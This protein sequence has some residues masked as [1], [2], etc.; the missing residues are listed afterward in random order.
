MVRKIAPVAFLAILIVAAAFVTTGKARESERVTS[1]IFTSYL[2][3]ARLAS[4]SFA[5]GTYGRAHR[6]SDVVDGAIDMDISW[7]N[8]GYFTVG[9]RLKDRGQIIDLGDSTINDEGVGIKEGT[10]EVRGRS[11]SI[12]HSLKMDGD[13]VVRKFAPY[14]NRWKI[15][16]EEAAPLFLP[17]VE[18]AKA[19]IKAGHVYLIRITDKGGTEKVLAKLRVLEYYP[20]DHVIFQWARL[21]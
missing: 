3:D 8:P 11:Y 2:R 21:R 13:K 15:M 14:T 10:V 17:P 6:D 4:F 7:L 9:C 1:G 18:K 20:S 5:L 16:L 12:Y 19:K